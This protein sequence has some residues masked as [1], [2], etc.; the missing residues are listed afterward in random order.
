MYRWSV[1]NADLAAAEPGLLERESA[2]VRP[3]KGE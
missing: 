2:R 1:P 3:P